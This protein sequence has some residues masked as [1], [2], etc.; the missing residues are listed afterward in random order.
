MSRT[1]WSFVWRLSVY[2]DEGARP[3][4]RES[5]TS[6]KSVLD[7]ARRRSFTRARTH[8]IGLD[9]ILRIPGSKLYNKYIESIITASQKAP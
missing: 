4:E 9:M 8:C 3:G 1:I 6:A 2:V 7:D 5:V